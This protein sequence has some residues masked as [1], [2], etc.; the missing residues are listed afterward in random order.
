MFYCLQVK[1]CSSSYVPCSKSTNSRIKALSVWQIFLRQQAR[2]NKNQHLLSDMLS[3]N[4]SRKRKKMFVYCS[5]RAACSLS[6]LITQG[7][8]LQNKRLINGIN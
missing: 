4:I 1:S 3:L 7:R 5:Q 8:W 6:V 2:K